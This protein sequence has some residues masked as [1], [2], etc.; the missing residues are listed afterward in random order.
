MVVGTDGRRYT[1]RG[2][3][4]RGAHAGAAYNYRSLGI[5]VIGNYENTVP[6]STVLQ[7]IKD[8]IDCAILEVGI[9]CM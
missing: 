3:D 7:A 6:S 2:F 4:R 9:G 8:T 5:A 1:G